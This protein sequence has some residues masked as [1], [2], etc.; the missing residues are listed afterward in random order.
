MA[1]GCLAM[2]RDALLL[3]RHAST[4]R[5]HLI[6]VQSTVEMIARRNGYPDVASYMD[7]HKLAFLS[8]WLGN[9]CTLQQLTAVQV[10][11]SL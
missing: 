7:F 11:G 1:V 6:L 5:E 4:F 8:D 3:C 10:T 2:E 9:S